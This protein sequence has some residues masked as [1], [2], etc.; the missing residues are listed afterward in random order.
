MCTWS[1]IRYGPM[2]Q[3]LRQHSAWHRRGEREGGWDTERE[4]EGEEKASMSV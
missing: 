2:E 3:V 4:E 1:G